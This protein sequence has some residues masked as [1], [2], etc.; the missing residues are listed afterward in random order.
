MVAVTGP[1]GTGASTAAIA[2]AQSLADDVRQGGLVLLADFCLHA[3]HAMLHHAHDI[4]PGVQELVEAHRGG[5]PAADQVRALAFTVAERNYQLLLGLRRARFWTTLRPRAFE[6][7]FDSLR[8]AYRVVVCD[9]DADVEGEDAG[10]S[11]D[12]EERHLMARTAALSADVVYVVGLPTMKGLHSLVRVVHDVLSVG[13]NA[14]TRRA[15]PEPGPEVAPCAGGADGNARTS[16]SRRQSG[17]VGL[18]G[19]VFLP[20]RRVDDA[21]R[22]G[23]RLPP[24]LGQPLAGALRAVLDR[25]KGASEPAGPTRVRP[26][27]LGTWTDQAVGE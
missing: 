21:L 27:S 11:L 3:E 7:A 19:P 22:D 9:I 20:G 13:A 25:H 17:P 2:L 6:A 4:V 23:V 24:G 1:G 12:V 15:R 5:T 14:G 10:G 8:R 16:S 18:A 26:G